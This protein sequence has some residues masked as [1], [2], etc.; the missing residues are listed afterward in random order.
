MRLKIDARA[1]ILQIQRKYAPLYLRVLTRIVREMEKKAAAAAHN[2]ID[3][4][5][6]DGDLC[7]K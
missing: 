2:D 5:G 4:E 3:I 7:A 1:A 6:P